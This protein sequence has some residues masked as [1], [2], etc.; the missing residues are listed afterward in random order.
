[1]W[2]KKISKHTKQI[3]CT[4]KTNYTKRRIRIINLALSKCV[5]RSQRRAYI[6]KCVGFGRYRELFFRKEGVN[7][8][9]GNCLY[10][11]VVYVGNLSSHDS[12]CVYTTSKMSNAERFLHEY[13]K[14]HPEVCK[15]YIERSYSREAKRN[16]KYMREDED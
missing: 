5:N 15:A 3:N 6:K 10:N 14:E 2:K 1:M 8:S 4:K 11:V 13:T 9:K 16:A 7:V 12:K